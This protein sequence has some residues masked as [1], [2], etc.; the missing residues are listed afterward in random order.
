MMEINKYTQEKLEFENIELHNREINDI[1][2]D[3]PVWLIHTGSYLLYGIMVVLLLGTAIFKYP[4]VV[5]G[6]V[7][8]DDFANVEWVVANSA[9]PIDAFFVEDKT[10]VKQGD[11]LGIRK[12]PAAV[13]DG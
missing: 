5:Q 12:N 1:L 8:I 13:E 7:V 11:T 4:D 10:I 6:T 3:A 2:G 9:G